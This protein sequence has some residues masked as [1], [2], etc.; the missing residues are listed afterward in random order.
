[1][2]TSRAFDRWAICYPT[3]NNIL[4]KPDARYSCLYP[5][6]HRFS[7]PS[8]FHKHFHVSNN[9]SP[10]GWFRWAKAIECLKSRCLASHS[11]TCIQ[12]MMP[13]ILSM[14]QPQVNLDNEIIPTHGDWMG[15]STGWFLK[16]YMVHRWIS[17][18]TY[19]EMPLISSMHHVNSNCSILNLILIVSFIQTRDPAQYCQ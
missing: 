11:H 17:H 10:L 16:V 7:I 13:L 14:F 6:S 5:S 2:L 19:M 15:I 12:W 8:I 4:S 1:M 3:L 18:S 9:L